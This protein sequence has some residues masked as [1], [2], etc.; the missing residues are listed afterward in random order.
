MKERIRMAVYDRAEGRCEIGGPDCNGRAEVVH[1][2]VHRG[3]GGRHGVAKAESEALGNLAAACEPCHR[4][5]HDG[6]KVT[7]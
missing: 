5:H 1:H 3:M 6:G 7:A 2:R 4:G